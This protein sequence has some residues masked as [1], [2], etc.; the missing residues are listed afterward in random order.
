MLA[1]KNNYSYKP[2]NSW[3]KF[4]VL[5]EKIYSRGQINK[6]PLK[7]ISTETFFFSEN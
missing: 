4:I 5:E 6:F 7:S 1:H 2:L 3:K